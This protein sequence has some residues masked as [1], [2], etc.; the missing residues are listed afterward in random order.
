MVTVR[1]NGDAAAAA[2]ADVDDD[3]DDGGGGIGV[4]SY[5]AL[6]HVPPPSTSS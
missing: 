1:E 4:A 3:D 6:E 2:A 5:G